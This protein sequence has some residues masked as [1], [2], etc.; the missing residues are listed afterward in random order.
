MKRKRKSFFQ[1]NVLKMIITAIL[2]F[3]FVYVAFI[4]SNTY[5]KQKLPVKFSEQVE[6]Y[7]DEYGLDRYLV[8]S[9]ISVESD[10]DKNAESSAGALGLM[11]IM[12]E[13][14][15]WMNSKYSLAINDI[16][17]F[18]PDTNIRIG[19]CY[20]SYLTKRFGST[21]LALIAYNGGEGNVRE[22][23]KKYSSDG[24]TLD[25]IPYKETAN[26]VKKVTTRYEI[27]SRIYS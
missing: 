21:E 15:D 18:S 10:F 23:L 11:Q 14:A 16:D 3:A 22:W 20:L 19:C 4:W 24:V 13:T 5:I 2:L 17:L 6:M 9:V 12:P 8:Y 27:Y 26:Y 7:S 25:T 1:S